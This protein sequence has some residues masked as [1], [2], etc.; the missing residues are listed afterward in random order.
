MVKILIRYG[1]ISLKKKNQSRFVDALHTQIA[2]ALDEFDNIKIQKFHGRFFVDCK[3]EDKAKVFNRLSKVF[4]LISFSEVKESENDMAEIAK[5]AIKVMQEIIDE[6][7]SVTFKVESRRSNKGFPLKSP[8]ISA[9]IGGDLLK[10][11]N[12]IKPDTL[13]VDVH[14]PEITLEVEVRNKS[15]VFSS[16]IQALGGMPYGTSGKGLVLLS[17]GIDSPVS[18]YMMAKRGLYVEALH[19]HSHPYTSQ[20]AKDKVIKLAEKLCEYTGEIKMHFINIAKVQEAINQNC[21]SEEMTVLSRRFMMRIASKIADINGLSCLV[22]GESL[23]QVA[24]QT[25]EGMT[26]IEDAANLPIF[27]PLIAFDKRDTVKISEEIDT[28]ETSILPF[29]DCCTVFLPDRVVTRPR[30]EKIKESE[31]KIDVEDLVNIAMQSHETLIVK[32]KNSLELEE[33]I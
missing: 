15:Y 1:E 18:L 7:G 20:R 31:T 9:Q 23:A 14:K 16:H 27:K 17:G 11:F 19:F 33:L 24:S 10:H 2:K 13:K 26:V 25:M 12:N 5:S 22:T 30:L 32:R 28:F 21:P 6:K 29:E 4:G 3:K 8:Q